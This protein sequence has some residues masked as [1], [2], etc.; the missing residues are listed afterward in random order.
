MANAGQ[1]AD[2]HCGMGSKTSNS[3]NLF[4]YFLYTAIIVATALAA[5][6]D[7]LI[8]RAA[9][10]RSI[11]SYLTAFFF[12]FLAWA[13]FQLNRLHHKRKLQPAIQPEPQAAL[14]LPQPAPA[15][16]VQQTMLASRKPA[17]RIFGLTAAQLVIVLVVFVAA[18]K[19][20]TWA[21]AS[22]QYVR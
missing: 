8:F 4:E 14:E 5:F 21:L 6:A 3:T 13:F 18:V 1:V 7:K 19:S 10:L 20:F 15:S 22:L 2:G 17:R 11:N 12:G 16:P 9:D